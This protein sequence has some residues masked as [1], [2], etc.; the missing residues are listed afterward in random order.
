MSFARFFWSICL[1]S[2]TVY[3][4]HTLHGISIRSSNLSVPSGIMNLSLFAYKIYA[5]LS[6]KSQPIA[7]ASA[8]TIGCP[9]PIRCLGLFSGS[10]LIEYITAS[11]KSAYLYISI[12]GTTAPIG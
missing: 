8:N 2:S 7:V 5:A 12:N 3:S 1:S 11:T 6:N 9:A 4:Q 10:P